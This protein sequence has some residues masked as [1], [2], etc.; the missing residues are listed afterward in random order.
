MSYKI[1]EGKLDGGDKKFAIVVSRFNSTFTD[2]LLGGA[3]DCLKRHSVKENNITVAYVPGAF[4]LPVTADKLAGTNNYDALICLGVIIRG[5]TPHFDFISSAT[6]SGIGQAALKNK[7]PIIFGV[8]TTDN[9]EQAQ[10]RSGT[11][12]GNKGW[13][14][15][16][17]AIEMTNLFGEIN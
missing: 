10:E 16:M 9:I 11:K 14:A 4:E 8:L 13:D 15:A 1:I 3:I 17:T 7:M 2:L 6:A 5:A 12:S